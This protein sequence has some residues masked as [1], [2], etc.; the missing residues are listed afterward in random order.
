VS[1]RIGSLAAALSLLVIS[2]SAAEADQSWKAVTGAGKLSEFMSGLK[3][4]RALPKGRTSRGEFNADGTGVLHSWNAS[5]PR[6]WEIVGEDQICVKE[7]R[8]TLCYNLEQSATD[9][10]LYRVREVTTGEWTEFRKVGDRAVAA[11]DAK[12]AGGKGGAAAPSADELA[13]ELSN[14]NTAVASLTLKTQFRGFDGD[15]PDASDQS[16]TTLLFQPI[17]PFALNSGAKVIWRPAVPLLV[18]QPLP[19]GSSGEF[20][21]EFGLGDI[22]FDLAY[23]PKTKGGLLFAYGFITSLPTAT[24]DLGT[25]QWTLGPE[26][27]IGKIS[28]KFVVGFFPNHQWDIAGSGDTDV[29]LTT[30]TAFLTFL[31]GGGWNWGSAPIATFDHKSDQWT[32]PLN[33]NVG[34]TIVLGGRPWKFNVELN[35]FVDQ[36]D[37]FGPE[38]LIGINITPVVNNGIAKWFGLGK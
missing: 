17:L 38:W 31:P 18:D 36:P 12:P 35:Y 4:E 24:N 16:S 1:F 7:R 13:A 6:T 26:I 3:A 8:V 9:P 30:V 11:E 34:K 14:P 19:D 15:L 20:D 28:K 10:E 33:V 25:D 29:N 5:M 2:F 32:L 22:A 37:A 23:A 21:G 27:L